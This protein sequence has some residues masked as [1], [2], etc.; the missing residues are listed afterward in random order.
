M[1]LFSNIKSGLG[2]IPRNVTGRPRGGG[3]LKRAARN[4]GQQIGQTQPRFQSSILQRQPQSRDEYNQMAQEGTLFG[5]QPTPQPLPQL[6]EFGFQKMIPSIPSV[7]PIMSQP[8][9]PGSATPGPQTGLSAAEL[10]ELSD[11]ELQRYIPRENIGYGVGANARSIDTTPSPEDFRA[12]LQSEVDLK[13]GER[14]F[15]ALAQQ[16]T[17]RPRDSSP[18]NDSSRDKQLSA[19]RGVGAP[20]QLLPPPPGFTPPTIGNTGGSGR[21]MGIAPPAMQQPVAD[22]TSG[23]PAYGPNEN[24]GSQPAVSIF[25]CT[26]FF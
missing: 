9:V 10:L 26:T 12:R 25:N 6:D 24:F 13:P 4:F 23:E 18:S 8:L 7:Q 1:G 19:L 20:Q 21:D 17:Y 3:F 11:E 16:Q 15:N 2:T 22:L 14:G 5:G